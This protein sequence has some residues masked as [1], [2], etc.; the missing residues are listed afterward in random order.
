MEKEAQL[1]AHVRD[2]L[3]QSLAAT[4]GVGSLRAGSATVEHR[5]LLSALRGD[6]STS[7]PDTAFLVASALA[8]DVTSNALVN[9]KVSFYL[10]SVPTHRAQFTNAATGGVPCAVSSGW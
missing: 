3:S 4:A 10:Y 2:A 5:T 9:I 7:S 1:V 8:N 6:Q